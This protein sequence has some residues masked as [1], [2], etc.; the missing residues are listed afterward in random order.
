MAAVSMT[1]GQPGSSSVGATGQGASSSTGQPGATSSTGQPGAKVTLTPR[2][3]SAAVTGD[4]PRIEGNSIASRLYR[5]RLCKDITD[6]KIHDLNSRAKKTKG[7]DGVKYTSHPDRYRIDS[8][9]RDQM[10]D[11]LIPEWLA[12]QSNGTTSRAD[13]K[14]GDQWPVE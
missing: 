11:K 5:K 4:E 12:W 13:G 14:L 1:T 2:R 8:T 7:P 9:Y 10:K 3:G 6:Q